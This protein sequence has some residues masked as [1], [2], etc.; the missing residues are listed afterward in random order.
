MSL[1]LEHIVSV[2]LYFYTVAYAASAPYH[3]YNISFLLKVFF[4][5]NF[6]SS[7]R[8]INKLC[9]CERDLRSVENDNG[10]E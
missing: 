8:Q 1:L 4:P 7:S 3:R 6:I 9:S 10:G 2:L 5:M